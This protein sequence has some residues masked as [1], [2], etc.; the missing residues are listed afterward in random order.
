MRSVNSA[1]RWNSVFANV[2]NSAIAQAV[3]V[4][5]FLST[6][7]GLQEGRMTSNRL[8][9][10]SLLPAPASLGKPCHRSGMVPA[11]ITGSS[12]DRTA[13]RSR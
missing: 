7:L 5:H 12:R 10:W 11:C 4:M 8:R 3:S 6:Y 1:K 13:I 2:Q 9:E